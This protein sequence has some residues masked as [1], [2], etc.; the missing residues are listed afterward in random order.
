M[1]FSIAHAFLPCYNASIPPLHR[2]RT[3]PAASPGADNP[4]ILL[5]F[6]ALFSSPYS[7]TPAERPYLTL[8]HFTGRNDLREMRTPEGSRA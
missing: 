5:P 4:I 3:Y 6:P 7:N 8:T 2:G 1:L